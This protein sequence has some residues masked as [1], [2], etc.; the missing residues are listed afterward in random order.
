MEPSKLD[1]AELL[2]QNPQSNLDYIVDGDLLQS[3]FL[4]E[5]EGDNVYVIRVS[6]TNSTV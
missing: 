3:K 2:K 5:L 6:K 1:L 4:G